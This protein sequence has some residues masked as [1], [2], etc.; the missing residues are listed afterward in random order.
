MQ[1]PYAVLFAPCCAGLYANGKLS[2]ND[3]WDMTEQMLEVVDP[4]TVLMRYASNLQGRT[5]PLGF[6]SG[7]APANEQQL[8]VSLAH[9]LSSK[10]GLV[11]ASHDRIPEISDLGTLQYH[12]LCIAGNP[13]IAQLTDIRF[14]PSEIQMDLYRQI[15]GY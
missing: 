2:L 9:L 5:S 7:S 3:D 13:P 8:F 15:R 12:N 6:R 14:S 10:R 4:A 1:G 11:V